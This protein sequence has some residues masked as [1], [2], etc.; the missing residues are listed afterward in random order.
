M[1]ITVVQDSDNLYL[2]LPQTFELSR[3]Y[4]NWDASTL[5]FLPMIFDFVYK[6]YEQF[7]STVEAITLHSDSSAAELF[8]ISTCF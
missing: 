5:I 2:T 1:Q 6:C 7:K 4:S 3:L 8:Q